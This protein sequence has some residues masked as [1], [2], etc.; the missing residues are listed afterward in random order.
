MGSNLRLE[1]KIAFVTGSTRG[2]GWATVCALAAHKATV[3][4]NS[5]SNE[6]LLQERTADIQAEYGV[7]SF[8]ILADASDPGRVT[9][10]YQRIFKRYKKLDIL[11]N[12]AGILDDSLH[13]MI[14]DKN[15]DKTF[16]VNAIG[17]IH[18]LQG[19][20]RLMDRNRSGSIINV[21]SIIGVRGNAGQVVYGASKAAVIGMTLSAAKELAEKNIRVNAVAPGFIETDMIKHLHKEKF[22]SLLASIKMGR[23]GKPE[24]VADVILFLA[25]D[26][27]RYVTGQVIA[28]DGGMI[29]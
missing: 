15:I 14:P 5:H 1:G 7:K 17:Y 12:N 23:I 21:A 2:I 29:I 13:G 18:H 22:D 10:C 16:A 26:L 9:S 28:V 3:V 25:S 6:H 27:S 24:D 11:V 8:G 4:L 19:A 20:A